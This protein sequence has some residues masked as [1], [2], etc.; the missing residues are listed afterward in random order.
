M[1]GAELLQNDALSMLETF[2]RILPSATMEKLQASASRTRFFFMFHI[3][4]AFSAKLTEFNY[5]MY[6]ISR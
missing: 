5:F 6:R 4:D 3:G 2:E 1:F